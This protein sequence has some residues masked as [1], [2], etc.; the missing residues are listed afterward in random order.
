MFDS[1]N[2][3]PTFPRPYFGYKGRG[4]KG[5][6]SYTNFEQQLLCRNIQLGAI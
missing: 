6:L 4:Q 2:L 5:S 1:T 3:Y